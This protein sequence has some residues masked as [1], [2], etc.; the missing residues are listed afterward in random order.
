MHT[1]IY[2]KPDNTPTGL[3]KYFRASDYQF[4]LVQCV[5]HYIRLNITETIRVKEIT[6]N[7]GLD[8][9][10]MEHMELIIDCINCLCDAEHLALRSKQ[11]HEYTFYTLG[12]MI[13][14]ES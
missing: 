14:S 2:E 4:L 8:T 10:S 5:Y 12:D 13:V 11:G 3:D 1:D 7:C 9:N 6:A